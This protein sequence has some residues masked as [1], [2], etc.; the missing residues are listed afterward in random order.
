MMRES[1]LFTPTEEEP[2]LTARSARA[3]STKVLTYYFAV[4][5]WR[6]THSNKWLLRCLRNLF[7]LSKIGA[8]L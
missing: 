2:Y 4:K 5:R 6:R 3:V 8:T 1:D 7:S